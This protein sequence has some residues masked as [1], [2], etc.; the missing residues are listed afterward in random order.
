MTAAA[1]TA[2][3]R[4]LVPEVVQTSATDCGPAALKCLLGGFGIPVSYGR[5]REACQT[6]VDGTSIDVLEDVAMQLGL[7]AEQI[8]VPLDHLL[9][10][11]TAALPAIVV[12]VLPG[13]ITHFVVAWR[14]HG[15]LVQLMDPA[16]GRRWVP[17]AQLLREAYLH[18]HV[19]PADG[20]RE[21]A[22]TA[23]FIA[24]LRRRIQRLGCQRAADGW[25]AAACA[26]PEWRALAALDAAVRMAQ[27]LVDAGGIDRGGEARRLVDACLE[28]AGGESDEAVPAAYWSV[29]P[30]EPDEEGAARLRLRGVVLVRASGR[31]PRE[32]ESAPVLSPE[33][34][35]A[36]AEPPQRPL[37]TLLAMLRQ[38]GVLGPAAVVVALALA[39]AALLAEAVV[40]RSLLDLAGEL[41]PPS[42]R[43]G[44]LAAL[45]AFLAAMLALELPVA[46]ALLAMGRRLEARL[47]LSFLGKLPH[48]YD[49]YFQSRLSSDMAD[50]CHGV[51]TVRLL[52]LLG[53][54]L[55]RACFSLALTAAAIVWLDPPSAPFA[56]PAAIVA[57]VVPLSTLRLL[58][59][60]DLRM[61]THA[62]ALAR[63][64]L[65][66]LL[67]LVPVRAHGAALAVRR[68]HE[69]LVCDWASA[70]Q[71]LLRAAVAAEALATVAGYAL[72]ALLLHAHVARGAEIGGVLLLTYWA[73]QLPVLGQQIAQAVRQYPSERNRVL[74]LIEPLGAP[75]ERRV[76]VATAERPAT[77]AALRFDD[78]TVVA[79]GQVI[80]EEL[81]LDVAPGEHVAIVGPS[82]AGKST[83]LG[84]VFGW[85]RPARG[86]FRVDGA[87]ADPAQTAA[88]RENA[89][90]VDPSIQLFNRS[91][92]EN[93]RYGAGEGELSLGAVITGACLE[94]VVER[95]PDG[96]QTR[97]GEGG[98]LVSGG[99][100]QRVRLGRALLRKDA[101][102]VGLDEPF[103]GLDR[104]RRRELLARARAWWRNATLLCVTHDVGET[105][106]FDRVV[107]LDG[108]R[109][110]EQGSPAT[111]AAGPSR[112]R[113]LL[114]AEAAV[115]TGAWAATAW[116]R[117][118]LAHGRM[119]QPR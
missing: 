14:R 45:A 116:R 74:R 39:A 65:D 41:G 11:E 84:L 102:F 112:Y 63:F 56:I 94:E 113:D 88:L 57:V 70:G 82:G 69:G 8:M 100:G 62:G 61:R 38:D 4:Y 89:A 86:T 49:R 2:R 114:D 93:V 81:T 28:R 24:P 75:E 35:A 16:M 107:V 44:A 105:V 13:G 90:W 29:R 3:R 97:L 22:G 110:V 32:A 98:G 31:R 83:L 15:A 33:L 5:L 68:E 34:L 12:V 7:H 104:E 55:V 64:H 60:R 43:L 111:L 72:A 25:I 58:A 52:P 118:R 40:F 36:L 71:A 119:E 87:S 47:R 117:L 19:V 50:R 42:Q 51:H 18:T 46:R 20:W 1:T 103:R 77:A 66:A 10:P 30:C 106:T 92:F 96:L 95:M 80:L 79:G 78:V 91:M 26:D 59:E 109:V 76:D 115:R 37:R 101:R 27:A 73:L 108:G 99:E 17:G 48:L 54:Q 85:H 67:G 9:L 6:D 21:W 53:G 23:D